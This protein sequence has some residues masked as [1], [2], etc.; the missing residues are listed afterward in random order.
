MSRLVEHLENP[1]ALEKIFQEDEET[2]RREFPALFAQHPDSIVLQVWQQRLFYQAEE[3]P[4]LSARTPAK[5][6]ELGVVILLALLAGTLARLPF[7]FDSLNAEFFYARNLPLLVFPALAFYYFW[8]NRPSQTIGIQVASAFCG[9]AVLINLLPNRQ[10]SDSIALACLHLPAV[11]WCSAG[12]TYTGTIKSSLRRWQYLKFNGELLVYLGLFLIGGLALTALTF[13]LF[14]LIG[15]R[16][17]DWYYNYLIAYGLTAAP[18]IAAYVVNLQTRSRIMPIVAKV[19]SPLVLLTL[20]GYLI[21]MASQ[22]K[23]PYS[24]REFLLLFNVMLVAVLAIIVFALSGRESVPT[25]I[26]GDYIHILLIGVAL[27]LDAIA[28]SAIVFRLTSYGFTPNR[29]AVLGANLVVS[30]NLV[31][32]LWHYLRFARGKADLDAAKTFTAGYLTVHLFWA[33]LVTVAFPFLF[34]FR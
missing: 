5:R 6:S 4:V 11:L 32:L 15:I 27:I 23:S 21:A 3:S 33:A 2:F 16:I 31:G 14:S 22:R 34:R 30:G 18:L 13:G 7:I 19:F 29:I 9:A 25:L 24:D 1:A 28:L 26:V 10:H 17:H 12:L 20:V 8:R